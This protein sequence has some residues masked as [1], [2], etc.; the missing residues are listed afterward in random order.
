[1]DG[2]AQGDHA[3]LARVRHQC[4]VQRL[5][6]EVDAATACDGADVGVQQ[7]AARCHHALL[8]VEISQSTAQRDGLIPGNRQLQDL[9]Q[10]Q[11]HLLHQQAA[12]HASTHLQAPMAIGGGQ[13][14]AHRVAMTDEIEFAIHAADAQL[15]RV[16]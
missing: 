8:E 6:R 16:G 1:M 9:K 2:A 11:A 5:L 3:E 12:D 7:Q 13:H 4:Q 10:V 14:A 15:G